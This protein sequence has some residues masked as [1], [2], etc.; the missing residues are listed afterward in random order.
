MISGIET[1]PI[2]QIWK[3]NIPVLMHAGALRLAGL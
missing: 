2:G 1:I 3:H